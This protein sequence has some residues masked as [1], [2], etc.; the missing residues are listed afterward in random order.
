M[1]CEVWRDLGGAFLLSLILF[2]AKELLVKYNF[3]GQ[4][5]ENATY[6]VLQHRLSET[7]GQ[8]DD[9]PVTVVDI[10]PLEQRQIEPGLGGGLAT[11]QRE[12]LQLL[13]TIVQLNRLELL[14]TWTCRRWSQSMLRR[15]CSICR[16]Q[17]F[18]STMN[19]G[20]L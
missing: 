1:K 17:P 3:A 15:G 16:G 2:A 18:L 10:S 12:L 14:S 4:M 5:F 6:E 19:I 7:L 9:I 20:F 8:A 11:P 13:E